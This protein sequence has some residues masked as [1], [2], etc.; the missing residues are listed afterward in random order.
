MYWIKGEGN[1]LYRQWPLQQIW[2]DHRESDLNDLFSRSQ[3]TTG[4]WTTMT[5]SADLKWPQGVGPESLSD[6]CCALGRGMNMPASANITHRPNLFRCTIAMYAIHVCYPCMLIFPSHISVWNRGPAC[7]WRWFCSW[8][9]GG[10]GRGLD[11]QPSVRSGQRGSISW[12]RPIPSR[13]LNPSLL[14]PTC[15]GKYNARPH[16]Y[17]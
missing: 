5:S 8:E 12:P 10:G 16:P 9:R 4:S 11:N 14:H 15:S 3:V 6:C 2:S 1:H 7:S 13:Q 17:R